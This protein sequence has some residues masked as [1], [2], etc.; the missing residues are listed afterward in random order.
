ML[1]YVPIASMIEE[2]QEYS[3]GVTIEVET[4]SGYLITQRE[5]VLNVLRTRYKPENLIDVEVGKSSVFWYFSKV[6]RKL[7]YGA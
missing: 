1:R 5:A 4:P 7:L 3:G 2:D 6:R